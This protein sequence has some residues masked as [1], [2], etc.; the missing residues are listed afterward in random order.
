MGDV[1]YGSGRHARIPQANHGVYSEMPQSNVHIDDIREKVLVVVVVVERCMLYLTRCGIERGQIQE[2]LA[3]N[4]QIQDQVRTTPQQDQ[5]PRQGYSKVTVE[6]GAAQALKEYH[7]T[8]Y[9]LC[10]L[11]PATGERLAATASA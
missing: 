3:A 8:I 4:S 10:S 2:H 7:S 11:F 9:I 5:H 6:T 1:Q